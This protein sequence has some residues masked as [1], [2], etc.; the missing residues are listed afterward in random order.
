MEKRIVVALMGAGRAGQEHATNLGSLLDVRVAPVCD[1][2]TAA[3]A[4]CGQ[5][6][7]VGQNH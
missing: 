5:I 4:E 3:R 1:L 2:V 6:C 7:P